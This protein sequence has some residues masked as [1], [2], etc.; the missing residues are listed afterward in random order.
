MS[1]IEMFHCTHKTSVRLKV[2]MFTIKLDYVHHCSKNISYELTEKNSLH[3]H[4][5]A[6][7]L[8]LYKNA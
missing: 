1:G 4:E 3:S 6:S 5:Q 2:E 7:L 8:G